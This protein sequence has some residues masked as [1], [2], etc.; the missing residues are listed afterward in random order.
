MNEITKMKS[1]LVLLF[2]TVK[3]VATI[4]ITNKLNDLLTTPISTDL[5]DN[6]NLTNVYIDENNSSNESIDFSIKISNDFIDEKLKNE[7]EFNESASR[8]LTIASEDPV[9]SIA[10]KQKAMPQKR[11]L[12][13]LIIIPC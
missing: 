12:F 13:G 10:V 5:N 2:F 4:S 8:N 1:I 11:S 6:E 9:Q 3:I 7:H